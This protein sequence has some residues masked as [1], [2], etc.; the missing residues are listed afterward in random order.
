MTVI[1]STVSSAKFR[2]I[3]SPYVRARFI[4]GSHRGVVERYKRP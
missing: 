2:E 1:N 3:K 4:F